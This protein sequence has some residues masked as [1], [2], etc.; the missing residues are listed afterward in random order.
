MLETEKTKW[1]ETTEAEIAN[2]DL[3]HKNIIKS[4]EAEKDKLM[5]VSLIKTTE[6][7]KLN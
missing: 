3:C 6:I 2:L 5:E 4:L 7:G 1:K